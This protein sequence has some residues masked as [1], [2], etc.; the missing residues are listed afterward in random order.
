[1]WLCVLPEAPAC[2]DSWLLVWLLCWATEQA[3]EGEPS[4]LEKQLVAH[5]TP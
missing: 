1:V 3:S 4:S 2:R 5:L